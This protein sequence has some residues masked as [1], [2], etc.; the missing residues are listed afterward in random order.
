LWKFLSFFVRLFWWGCLELLRF[1]GW[2]K[3]GV[4]RW[5]MRALWIF[6]FFKRIFRDETVEIS[7]A[8]STIKV[9]FHFPKKEQFRN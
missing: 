6:F 2:K 1:L 7:K 3:G 8:H 4:K 5:K 9:P